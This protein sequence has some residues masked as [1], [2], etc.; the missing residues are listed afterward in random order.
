MI[1]I[2]FTVSLIPSPVFLT[3]NGTSHCIFTHQWSWSGEICLHARRALGG[4]VFVSHHGVWWLL[5]LSRWG[6]ANSAGVD[7]VQKRGIFVL[8]VCV[9]VCV[10]VWQTERLGGT[11][12]INN[13]ELECLDYSYLH[14]FFSLH[15]WLWSPDYHEGPSTTQWFLNTE[16]FTEILLWTIPSSHVAWEWDYITDNQ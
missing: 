5:G 7:C 2:S 10:C 8:V 1:F 3:W 16:K 13:H 6:A 12:S 14:F 11:V 4:H 9:C 15:S